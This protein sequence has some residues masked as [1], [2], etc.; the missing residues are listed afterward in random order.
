MHFPLT[1]TTKR[2]EYIQ[3]SLLHCFQLSGEVLLA[4]LHQLIMQPQLAGYETEHIQT[5]PMIC[6]LGFIEISQGWGVTDHSYL[7]GWQRIQPPTFILA[8]VDFTGQK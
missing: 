7:Q 3:L 5:N 4:F 6:V 2:H 1:L 8:E